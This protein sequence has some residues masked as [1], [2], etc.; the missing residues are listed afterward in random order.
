[1][2]DVSPAS[3]PLIQDEQSD[4]EYYEEVTQ[5]EEDQ[6]VEI[7]S[8]SPVEMIDPGTIGE[9]PASAPS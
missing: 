9:S 2:S 7:E 5:E 8:G 1:M 6:M 3:S 4:D